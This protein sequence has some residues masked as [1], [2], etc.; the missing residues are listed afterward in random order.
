MGSSTSRCDRKDNLLKGGCS[1]GAVEFPSSTMTVQE[2]APLSDKASGAAD[3][4][5][6]IRPQKLHMAL[7]PGPFT[8]NR[9]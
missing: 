1:T 4:V 5:T 8:H 7:R 6:Q 3:D 2:D 9:T